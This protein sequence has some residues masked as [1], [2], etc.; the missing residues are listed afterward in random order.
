VATL[1]LFRELEAIWEKELGQKL[2]RE[3]YIVCRR[4]T[5]KYAAD[6]QNMDKRFLKETGAFLY[7]RS[8]QAERDLAKDR[9][10]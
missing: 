10:N 8:G 1:G 2:K 9:P 7:I 4:V 5:P 3:C 6:K